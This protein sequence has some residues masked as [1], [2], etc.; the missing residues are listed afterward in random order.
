MEIIASWA[1]NK[2]VQ[3]VVAGLALI[4]VILIPVAIR[5]AIEIHGISLF[6]L[7]AYDGLEKQ[8]DDAKTAKKTAE[9]DRDT[10]KGNAD[11]LK[12][13]LG[14]CNASIDQLGAAGDTL[15]AEA[16]EALARLSGMQAELDAARKRLAAVPGSTQS[17]P[18][19]DA[20]FAGAFR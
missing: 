18:Q 1:A 4:G 3:L 9:A 15:A 12:K 14:V 16:R 8:R 7:Y 11:T 2:M 6:G 20:I 13:G 10:W 19:V 17:C 5:Q